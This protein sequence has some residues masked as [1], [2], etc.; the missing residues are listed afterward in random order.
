M[1]LQKYNQA[2]QKFTLKKN[3]KILIG[4]WQIKFFASSQIV[5]LKEHEHESLEGA[6]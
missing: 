4:G 6:E 3:K 2:S 1:Y 5:I